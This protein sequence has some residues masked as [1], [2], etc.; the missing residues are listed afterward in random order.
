MLTQ[1][2]SKLRRVEDDLILPRVILEASPLESKSSRLRA[3]RFYIGRNIQIELERNIE[4][5]P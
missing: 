5:T 4:R 2:I 3:V 1:W